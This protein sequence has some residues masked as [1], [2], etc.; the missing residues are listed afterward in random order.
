MV[1]HCGVT[2]RM[3]LLKIAFGIFQATYEWRQHGRFFGALHRAVNVDH[4]AGDRSMRPDGDIICSIKGIA[5]GM[6]EVIVGIERGF[7]RHLTYGTESIHLERGSR[8]ADKA[9][10]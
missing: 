3:L 6:V 10:D 1:Q 9:F 8:R 7:Y 4:A 2:L 5:V